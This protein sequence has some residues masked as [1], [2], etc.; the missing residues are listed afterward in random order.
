MKILSVDDSAI[1][2]KIIRNGVEL[3]DYEL[4]EAGDG[5]EALAMLEQSTDNIKLILLDWNMPGMDG[6]DFLH[7]IKETPS[8]KHLPVMMVTT[9]SEKENIIKAIQAGAINYM[10]KPFS[11]EEL[12]KKIIECIGEGV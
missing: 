12:I 10:V 6:L 8:L 1:I 7:K 5:M 4:L 11:I 9:E 2:R 3:L